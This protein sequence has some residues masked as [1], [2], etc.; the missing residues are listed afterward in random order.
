MESLGLYLSIPFCKSKCTY[1]NF[2]SGVFPASYFDQYIGRLEH[3]LSAIREKAAQWSAALPEVIDT[4]YLG[5]GTPSLL[6][7]DLIRRLFCRHTP[8]IRHSAQR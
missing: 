1:C 6:A 5:G 4:I 3:D 2:A 7:A 8:R